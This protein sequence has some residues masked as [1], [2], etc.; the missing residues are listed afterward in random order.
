MTTF[1]Y[2]RKIPMRMLEK[3]QKIG[4][5]KKESEMYLALAKKQEAS[6]NELAKSTSTNRTVC[7]NTLQQFVEKGMPKIWTTLYDESVLTAKLENNVVHVNIT[8]LPIKHIFFEYLTVGY[9]QQA[10]KI[11]GKKSVEKCIRGFSK[12][13][14]DIYYQYQIKDS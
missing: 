14:S 9:F 1:K 12:G 8:Q 7:Y 5:T 4:L 10:L 13:D 3:L 11:F 6:A 2:D